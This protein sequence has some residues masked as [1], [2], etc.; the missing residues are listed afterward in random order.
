MVDAIR[1]MLVK[2]GDKNKVIG[3]YD[4][5]W[6]KQIIGDIS[7]SEYESIIDR[8]DLEINAVK[9]KE[10]NEK[11]IE[12]EN[13]KQEKKGIEPVPVKKAEKNLISVVEKK[14]KRSPNLNLIKANFNYNNTRIIRSVLLVDKKWLVI[15]FSIVKHEGEIKLIRN[16]LYRES[17]GLNAFMH[18]KPFPKT[19]PNLK[20]ANRLFGIYVRKKMRQGLIHFIEN[21]DGRHLIRNAPIDPKYL[22]LK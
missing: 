4:Q 12:H 5:S 8:L 9:S 3:F 11:R 6:I 2:H 17:F 15:E 22:G 7:R 14:K 1:K 19:K 21:W 18:F 13:R 16:V 10:H 20:I